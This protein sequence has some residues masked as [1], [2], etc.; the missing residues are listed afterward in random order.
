MST[1]TQILYHIVFA[2]K[3]RQRVLSPEK[4]QELYKCIWGILRNKDCH[5]YRIG[6]VEDHVHILTSLH[7][8]VS[9][10]D[11]LKT[12]K[13]STSMWIK[14]HRLFPQF[15]G[16]QEGY[17]AFTDSIQEKDVLVKYI[18]GQEEHHR[19][20]TFKEELTELLKQAGVTYEERHLE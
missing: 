17:S 19:M 1:F 14:E 3:D 11:L 16:W 4:R 15:E 2:T 7:P 13:V 9:L 18:K 20:R 12:I 8:G 6:G 5:L 10:A